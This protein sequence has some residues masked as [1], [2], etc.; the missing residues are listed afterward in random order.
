MD[1]NLFGKTTDSLLYSWDEFEDESFL[2]STDQT[3]SKALELRIVENN[4]GIFANQYSIYGQPKE[5]LDSFLNSK[6]L[7]END[8]LPSFINKVKQM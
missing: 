8:N 6:D 5:S 4:Y 7:V 2:D 1:F 3:F